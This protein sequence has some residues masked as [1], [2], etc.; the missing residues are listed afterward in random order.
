V[1]ARWH[2]MPARQGERAATAPS[3]ETP[4]PRCRCACSSVLDAARYRHL[5]AAISGSVL[6]VAVY[7]FHRHRHYAMSVFLWQVMP[8]PPSSIN[9]QRRRR[10]STSLFTASDGIRVSW[11]AGC[12]GQHQFSSARPRQT[13]AHFLPPPRCQRGAECRRCPIV[14]TKKVRVRYGAAN[15]CA[16]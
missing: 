2:C 8:P 12:L 15:V 11:A 1:N 4:L 9:V 7:V 16:H 6:A 3:A 14:Y 13:S 10:Y 5:V